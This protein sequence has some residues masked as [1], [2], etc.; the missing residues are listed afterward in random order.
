[1]AVKQSLEGD[2]RTILRDAQTDENIDLTRLQFIEHG[3]GGDPGF[4]DCL[5]SVTHHGPRM[6]GVELKR[7]KSVVGELRPTQRLWHKSM[8][9]A[10]HVT[11][12][13]T[14]VTREKKRR[15]ID[16][17]QLLLAS[18]GTSARRKLAED[19]IFCVD[20]EQFSLRKML[21][22]IEDRV[23]DAYEPRNGD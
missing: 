15:T 17:F 3:K 23:I 2:L 7:G 14:L 11:F 18:D 5:V 21:G 12:G 9:M 6:I 8:L 1:M 13:L 22:L 10:G 16:L 20:E 4:P 19:L